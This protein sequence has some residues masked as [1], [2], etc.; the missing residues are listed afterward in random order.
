MTV[1]TSFHRVSAETIKILEAYPEL[2]DW[3]LGYSHDPASGEKLG[4]RDAVA[5]P[6]LSIEKAWD[7]IL[8]L[9][10]GTDRHEAYQA[11]H[12]SLWEEYDGCEE[13]RLFSPRVVKNGF[14]SLELLKS[15][16]LRRAALKRNL[17][18]YNGDPV[19]YLLDDTLAHFA[20]LRDFWRAAAFAGE[21]IIACT[22]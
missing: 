8:I 6:R 4:F 11:L 16:E 3:L 19:D 7:E 5:P 21:A 2:M 10:A 15:D 20:R 14:A 17:R 9:L 12:I 1:I 13:I 18:T 22:G